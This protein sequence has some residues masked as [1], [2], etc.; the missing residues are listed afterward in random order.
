[1]THEY[2]EETQKIQGVHPPS[3]AAATSLK[4]TSSGNPP[5]LPAWTHGADSRVREGERSVRQW[6]DENVEKLGILS[7][8]LSQLVQC[9]LDS[10]PAAV[11][12][13]RVQIETIICEW[14]TDHNITILQTVPPPPAQSGIATGKPDEKGH[15]KKGQ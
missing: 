15:K 6:L 3:T 5:Q 10:V 12:L 7:L 8:T 13:S 14:A 9:V 4:A 11:K 1:M 2:D